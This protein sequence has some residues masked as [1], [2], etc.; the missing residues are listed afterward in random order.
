LQ[1]VHSQKR[2]GYSG[3]SIKHQDP[4][5]LIDMANGRLE[6]NPLSQKNHWPP[7]FDILIIWSDDYLSYDRL[8]DGNGP[9]HDYYLISKVIHWLTAFGQLRMDSSNTG[10]VR[11]YLT[12]LQ[13]LT[14]TLTIPY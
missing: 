10:G 4:H 8:F 9:G 1:E 7:G 3:E 13:C 2:G 5:G 6:V 12:L 14:V 11:V